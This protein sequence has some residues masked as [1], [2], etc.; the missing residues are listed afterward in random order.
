MVLPVYPNPISIDNL[1]TEFGVTGQKSLQDFYAGGG[2]VPAN[3]LGY[4]SG[5]AGV[6]IPSSGAISLNNFHGASAVFKTTISSN[7]EQLDLRQYVVNQGWNQSSPVEVTI[8]ENVW[9]T[10]SATLRSTP[11]TA[12]NIFG[13]WSNGLKIYLNGIIAGAGGWGGTPLSVFQSNF[14]FGLKGER[15]GDAIR[16]STSTVGMTVEIVMGA[17]AAIMGGGGGGAASKTFNTDGYT[18]GAGG[19]AGA[20]GAE[21]GQGQGIISSTPNPGRVNGLNAPI[22]GINGGT[23]SHP[24][25]K[26]G[27]F[28]TLTVGGGASS[29]WSLPTPPPVGPTFTYPAF[30]GK[31][32]INTSDAGAH[33]NYSGPQGAGGGGGY[34]K[35][36]PSEYTVVKG[37]DG[38]YTYRVSYTLS[39]PPGNLYSTGGDSSY[40]EGFNIGVTRPTSG[41]AGGGG[42]GRKGGDS[43]DTADGTNYFVSYGGQPGRAILLQDRGAVALSGPGQYNYLGNIA[44]G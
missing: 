6:A 25:L 37:A 44:Y 15:G 21:G 35:A 13:N 2:I 40:T 20:G 36:L 39:Y 33:P 26:N 22:I 30:G 31:Q 16:I 11:N 1:R 24:Y 38:G 28:G 17:N 32:G 10:G 7:Q 9:I 34:T 8:N 18:Y 12:L 14:P 23:N 41:G 3:T 27:Q 42:W 43:Y 29:G 19:G 4:P 5:G